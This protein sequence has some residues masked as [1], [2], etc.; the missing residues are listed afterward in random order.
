MGLPSMR[1]TGWFQVAWSADLEV[2]DVMP[3]HYF[4]EDLVAFR[5]LDGAVRV[6]DAHCQAPRRRS[7]P[8]RLRRRG[9]HP[10]PVPR[11]GVERRRRPQ[12]PHPYERH[13]DDV[14][15]CGAGPPPNSTSASTSGTDLRHP[16]RSGPHPTHGAELDDP[17]RQ[18]LL[19][20]QSGPDEKQFFAGI[21]VHPQVGRREA[22]STVQHY[23]FVHQ[24]SRSAR[25]C[26][27][28]RRDTSSGMPRLAS[29]PAILS[30]YVGTA[31]V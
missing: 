9:R 7:V 27:L 19:P 4:G 24:V 31:S 12:R 20:V 8:R 26:S 5:D 16:R 18:P 21:A 6:L 17:D 13:A 30:K 28:R 29:V 1:P 14:G 15:G 3:L 10:M 2:G 11:L 25:P 23:R 22:R